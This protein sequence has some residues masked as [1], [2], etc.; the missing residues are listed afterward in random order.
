SLGPDDLAAYVTSQV[1][2]FFPD[3]RVDAGQLA[4]PLTRALERAEHCFSNL[5]RK[6]FAQDDRT[7][8]NHLNTDQYAMFLYLLSNT[9]FRMEESPSLTA[10]VYALNKALHSIDAFYEVELPDIFL[11]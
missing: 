6:Y 2:A 10:K 8:F 3:G 9:L 1:G 5:R 11:F 7:V 4:R